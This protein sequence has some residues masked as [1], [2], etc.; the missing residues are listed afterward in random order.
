MYNNTLDGVS[1]Y[2]QQSLC[3]S[4]VQ[5]LD[6]HD[7][8]AEN[9]TRLPYNAHFN[10]ILTEYPAWSTDTNDTENTSEAQYRSGYTNCMAERYTSKDAR[11]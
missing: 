2:V 6:Q 8:N 10:D 1:A 11:Q 7:A 5:P 9:F 3:N 4:L